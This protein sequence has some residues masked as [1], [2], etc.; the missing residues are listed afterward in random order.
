MVSRP[1][2]ARAAPQHAQRGSA[3]P[4]ALPRPPHPPHLPLC[5]R[6]RW[7][8]RRPALSPHAASW[9]CTLRLE[10]WVSRS[11]GNPLAGMHVCVC[12]CVLWGGVGGGSGGG[13]G[14]GGGGWKAA[15]AHMH[16]ATRRHTIPP[17]DATNALTC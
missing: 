8:R 17:T 16:P 3:W 9:P 12:V 11:L 2:R 15:E 7:T 13:G 1:A 5:P 4:C 14:V 10:A 6:S